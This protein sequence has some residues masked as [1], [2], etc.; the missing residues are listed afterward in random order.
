[1][2]DDIDTLRR[3]L[4]LEQQVAR[5]STMLARGYNYIHLPTALT[6]PTFSNAVINA[7]TYTI[8]ATGDGGVSYTFAYPITAKALHVRCSGRW[9]ATNNSTV[10]TAYGTGGPSGAD[11]AP[12]SRSYG[13]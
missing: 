9:A 8:G 10:L 5:L 1:M 13:P 2:S 12:V 11:A 7:G 4:K 3:L 6:C